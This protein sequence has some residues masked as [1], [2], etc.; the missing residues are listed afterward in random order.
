MT[1]INQTDLK[2][3]IGKEIIMKRETG[4]VLLKISEFKNGEIYAHA[5]VV[6]KT[7]FR[8]P[9]TKEFKDVKYLI[10]E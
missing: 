1:E 8:F 3:H 2:K 6:T 9:E 5:E 7:L 4:D 10:N